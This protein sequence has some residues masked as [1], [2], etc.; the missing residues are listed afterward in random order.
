MTD[1]CVSTERDPLVL[2]PA[3]GRRY[4][5]GS[6]LRRL[7]GRR[8]RV[9]PETAGRYSISG[10][11]WIRTQGDRAPAAIKRTTCSS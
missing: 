8:P 3:E 5:D 4:P 6:T 9:T 1:A 7:Q 10:G 2:A 11:G